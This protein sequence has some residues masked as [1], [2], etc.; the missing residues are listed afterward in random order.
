M[1]SPV[2][3]SRRS[4]LAA[5]GRPPEA[6]A[7]LP[8]VAVDNLVDAVFEAVDLAGQSEIAERY[9]VRLRGRQ[10]ALEGEQ[11]FERVPFGRRPRTG[12]ALG[13]GDRAVC[14]AV[15]LGAIVSDHHPVTCRRSGAAAPRGVRIR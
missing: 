8:R 11:N 9:R 3:P 6:R 5:T 1:V 7:R 15:G 12:G 2:W 4:P 14:R 10:T 13:R